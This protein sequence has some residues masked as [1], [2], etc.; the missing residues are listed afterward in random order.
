M[1]FLGLNLLSFLFISWQPKSDRSSLL[2]LSAMPWM[3]FL[4]ETLT[5]GLGQTKD[6]QDGR[7]DVGKSSRLVGDLKRT[8]VTSDDEG[9]VVC[10]I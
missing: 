10:T 2:N 3:I 7:S 6:V 5:L 9:D 4:P 1:L 8:L